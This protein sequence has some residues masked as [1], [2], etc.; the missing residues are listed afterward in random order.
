MDSIVTTTPNRSF[1]FRA[2]HPKMID[3]RPVTFAL[4]ND[5]RSGGVRVTVLMAN[6]L[7]K[8]GHFCRIVC[9]RKRQTFLR[10]TRLLWDSIKGKASHNNGWFHL[11]SGDI[12]YYDDLDELEY[13]ADEVIFAV[14]TYMV[15]DVRRM[16][17]PV[18]KVRFN[19]GMPT[20]P[21]VGF[22]N[23]WKGSM[24]TITVSNTLIPRLEAESG[25]KVLAV[26]P[27]GIDRTQYYQLSNHER[28]GIGATYAS[29]P[30][31][32]PQA[33]IKVLQLAHEKWPTVPQYVFGTEVIPAGLEHT[34]YTQLPSVEEACRIYNNA[35]VWLMTSKTEGLPGVA[36]EAMS[37]GCVMVSSDNDGSLEIIDHN[38]NGLIAKQDDL[39]AYLKN[40][41]QVIS[42]PDT[43][44]RLSKAAIETAEKMTWERAA[45][46][47]TNF[48]E[49]L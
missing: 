14:G 30:N 42:S 5:Y 45:Q 6:E 4:P 46:K 36:L 28:D 44:D 33:L 7:M 18:T 19:H 8:R 1:P 48:L 17:D 2:T 26:I 22:A 13:K 37:C 29:H 49:T 39:T 11:F 10:R 47:M 20:N 41:E 24:P 3:K 31:K 12:T 23:A 38:V 35:K 27:N 34:I 15:E 21:Q 16:T 40:I 32:D 25:E 43:F 9:P